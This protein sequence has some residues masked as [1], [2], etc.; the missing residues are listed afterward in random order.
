LKN[1]NKINIVI[2]SITIST[3]LIKCLRE[4]NNQNYKKFFVTI[5]LDKMGGKKVPKVN[6]K[7]N[8]LIVGKKNMS[9]KRNFAVKKFRTKY[10][11]FIDSDTYPHKNWLKVAIKLLA[12]KKYDVVG[13]P[14]IP[15]PNQSYI[16]KI[17]H[18]A[19]RSFFVTGYLNF[20]KYKAKSRYCDW[21]ESC[22]LIMTRSFFLKYGGMDNKRYTGEDKEFFE[23]VRKTNPELK[24]Y[25]SP[26]LFIYHRERQLTGFLLQRMCFG[27]DFLNLV[28]PS[29]GIKGFQPILP[30]LLFVT[31]LVILTSEI[32]LIVKSE[33]L[34]ISIM[35]IN[36]AIFLNIM[37][38]IKSFKDLI[39]T[40]ITI[41][42]ANISFA[43][44]G[45]LTFL[46]LKKILV[47]KVYTYSRQRK[48]Q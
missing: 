6:Y 46:G 44:G 26:D 31:M 43:L 34:I 17:C 10:I 1:K 5:V 14:N 35:I 38:Y 36:F 37:S 25:Y 12:T 33:I 47:N 41:N 40:I 9:Y 21:L 19:K 42:F 45:I 48:N 23:R 2:P 29:S 32:N 28:K 27:M 18:Y 7:I 39:L 30:I 20:R 24:V 8:I 16:E 3:E 13:G 22:N 15:F 4:I 11:A